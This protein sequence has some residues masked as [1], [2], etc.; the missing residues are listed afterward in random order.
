MKQ[1]LPSMYSLLLPKLLKFPTKGSPSELL[2]IISMYSHR[3]PPFLILL[4][5]SSNQNQ[6]KNESEANKI[7]GYPE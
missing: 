7:I 3:L 5:T 2:P 4:L 6:D 1:L